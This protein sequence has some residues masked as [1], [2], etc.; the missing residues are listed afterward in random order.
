MP[1]ALVILVG[2]GLGALCGLINGIGV[3]YIG[4]PPFIMT[5]GMM[6]IARGIPP[7]FYKRNSDL[8]TI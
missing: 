6:T 1:I 4:F 2:V 5:L 7:C 8:R 3:S